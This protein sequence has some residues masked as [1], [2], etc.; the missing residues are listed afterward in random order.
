MAPAF[1]PLPQCR[2]T[3]VAV[4]E[5]SVFRAPLRWSRSR[6][7]TVEKMSREPAPRLSG[8]CVVNGGMSNRR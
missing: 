8:W 5:Q 3:P 6:V 4:V 7:G 2:A 1:R